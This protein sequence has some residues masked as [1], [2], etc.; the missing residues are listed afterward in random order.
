MYRPVGVGLGRRRR[1][2]RGPPCSDPL[3]AAGPAAGSLEP[4]TKTDEVSSRIPPTSQ[5]LLLRGHALRTMYDIISG[6]LAGWPLCLAIQLSARR[7]CVTVYSQKVPI[8]RT[9]CVRKRYSQL[10]PN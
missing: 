1:R 9:A 4:K 6:E 7:V 3:R 5:G 10:P 8:V 2:G